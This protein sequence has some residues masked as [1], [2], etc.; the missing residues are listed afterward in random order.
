MHSDRV[1]GGRCG[2]ISKSVFEKGMFMAITFAWIV[3]NRRFV[4][5]YEQLTA[6]AETLIVR[7]TTYRR[8]STSKP[9]AAGPGLTTSTT[10]WALSLAQRTSRQSRRC[11]SK[12]S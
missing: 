8:R 2:S 5:D 11:A 4:S 7:S 12:A 3:K 9:L 6:V 10:M 1:V